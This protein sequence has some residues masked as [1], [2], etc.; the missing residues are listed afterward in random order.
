MIEKNSKFSKSQLARIFGVSRQFLYYRHIKRIKDWNIKIKIEQVLHDFPS[1]GYRRIA[2]HLKMNRKPVQRV[3]KLFD[4]KAYRRRGRKFRKNKDKSAINYSNLLLER[5]PLYPNNIWATDFTYIW[6]KDRFIY[7]CTVID[8][9]A[10]TIVG[11]S[12][13]VNHDRWL[14]T[15]AFLDALRHNPRPEILHSD[16]GKE[17]TSRDY[18][19]LV[20][21][22]N[23]I[24]SMSRL[25]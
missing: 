14:V 4:M 3:M 8:L 19:N 16:H 6:F 5:I 24:R 22:F 23:I 1:Y 12:V 7:L 13:S 17:Y 15:T 25:A 9:F 2:K 20:K 21:E 11:F 18:D 10:R